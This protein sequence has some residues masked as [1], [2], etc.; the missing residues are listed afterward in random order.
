S[1]VRFG[2][3]ENDLI[4]WQSIPYQA[5]D[6]ELA[7]ALKAILQMPSNEQ[8]LVC[9]PDDFKNLERYNSNS[10][11]FLSKNIEKYHAF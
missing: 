7:G 3:G 1:V 5:Y 11:Y 2:D 6:K 8:L 9:L 4:L 10:R